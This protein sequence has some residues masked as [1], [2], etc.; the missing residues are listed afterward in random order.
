[1]SP[2][3]AELGLKT[4]IDN[5]SIMGVINRRCEI[6]D[7]PVIEFLYEDGINKEQD[8]AKAKAEAERL[9]AEQM[10]VRNAVMAARRA[11]KN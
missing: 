11:A 5:A 8:W 1:M 2:D 6:C 7:V 3:Q 4:L 9:E 10:Q